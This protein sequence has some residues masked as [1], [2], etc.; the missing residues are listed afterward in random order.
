MLLLYTGHGIA[1]FT[2]KGRS[3]FLCFENREDTTC[4]QL[5]FLNG[6]YLMFQVSNVVHVL[7]FMLISQ[8]ATRVESRNKFIDWKRATCS[9]QYIKH[10]YI[11]N[12]ACSIHVQIY[13]N[14][15]QITQPY[16]SKHSLQVLVGSFP[17]CILFGLHA[18]VS[19]F[20]IKSTQ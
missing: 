20:I 19:R 12:N 8:T 2:S 15:T 4:N 3:L 5:F 18:K 13:H 7:H 14:K 11:Y 9:T 16:C 17:T 6:S 10:I 1:I